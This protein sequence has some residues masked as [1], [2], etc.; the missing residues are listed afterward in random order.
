MNKVSK[1]LIKKKKPPNKLQKRVNIIVYY[2][3]GY[4]EFNE[5][6]SKNMMDNKNY[7]Q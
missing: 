4:F 7:Q 1:Q 2:Y 3:L 6:F 5:K